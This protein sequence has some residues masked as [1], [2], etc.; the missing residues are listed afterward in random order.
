MIPAPV[1]NRTVPVVSLREHELRDAVELEER[2]A[3]ALN[4][5]GIVTAWR[6]HRPGYWMLKAGDIVGA[7]RVP[8]AEFRIAPKIGIS[9]LM[10]LLGYQAEWN[11]W[12]HGEVRVAETDDV[13]PVVAATFTRLAER[14]LSQGLLR[15]YRQVEDRL[16][17]VRGKVR[18]AAQVRRQHL[19]PL[20]VEVTFHDLTVDIPENRLLLAAVVRL[21]KL[22]GVPDPVRTSLL[23]ITRNLASVTAL[24]PG[25][26]LPMWQ[27]TRLNAR[28]HSVIRLAELVLRSG[29]FDLGDG[30]IPVDG[31]VLDMDAVFE[32]FI[33]AALSTALRAHG[34][35]TR[36][37][38]TSRHLDQAHRYRLRPDLVCY[39][40]D[41]SPSSVADAKYKSGKGKSSRYPEQ[42]V[43]QMMAY[44]TR[45]AVHSGHLVYAEG[46]P[47][48]TLLPIV[49]TEMTIVQHAL[50]LSAPPTGL[51][52]QIDRIAATMVGGSVGAPGRPGI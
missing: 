13:L 36:T 50:D 46:S 4:A 11:G 10:F 17:L 12:H 3:A 5:T 9:R 45:F 33:C 21:L 40:A 28:C 44:C 27:P 49:D 35:R 48:Q 15:G 22:P 7:F 43:Y 26:P 52:R 20:P 25:R 37:Q 41:G 51:L 38:D 42:D 6:A 34:Y 14:A 2:S 16:P 31:F 23:R 29:S 30:V 8:G 47:P 39:A 18:T 24:V 19:R 32:A 1:S